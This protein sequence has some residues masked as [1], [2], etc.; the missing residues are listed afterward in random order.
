[1]AR[2]RYYVTIPIVG[3]GNPDA[4]IGPRFVTAEHW[5][6]HELFPDEMIHATNHFTDL[7]TRQLELATAEG[8][9]A[10]SD[11]QRD[12]WFVTKLVMA[13]FHH[14][15]FADTEPDHPRHRGRPLGLLRHRARRGP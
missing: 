1:M 7:V 10:S 5:R 8:L 12:A 11:P 9:L 2:L 6:L 15:A 14:Y 4:G 13:V 3:L